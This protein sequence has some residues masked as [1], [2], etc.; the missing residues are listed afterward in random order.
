MFFFGSIGQTARLL[1]LHP[2]IQPLAENAYALGNVATFPDPDGIYRRVPIVFF[3]QESWIPSLGL[4]VFRD[5]ALKDP[6]VL[7]KDGLRL[8][9]KLLPLDE[10]KSFLL[11]YYGNPTFSRFSAFNVI[12]SSVALQE[13]G[14]PVYAQEIFR[15]KIVFVGYT[16]P[17]LFD[18]KPTPT[19]SRTPGTV[20]HATLAA[21]IL[22]GDFRVRI[23][24]YFALALALGFG[25]AHAVALSRLNERVKRLAQEVALLRA[26]DAQRKD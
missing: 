3:Y 26:D 8:D 12:Q 22:H 2:P 15:D 13:G 7:E 1:V 10:R 11:H 17:G 4:A 19:S 21:N 25:L 20:I 6:A 24:P 14:K 16:A 23:S 9:E 5:R 18:L